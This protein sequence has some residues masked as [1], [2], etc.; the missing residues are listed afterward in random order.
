[1]SDSP[2]WMP[3]HVGDYLRDTGHLTV[4]EHGAYLLLIM[5]YWQDGSLPESDL[6][7][8]RYS[9]LNV[10]QWSE[11]RD[12]ILPMFEKGPRGRSAVDRLLKR[13]LL[14]SIPQAIRRFVM[15]RDG[16]RCRYCGSTAGPFELDHILPWS[17]G[18]K[19][20]ASNLTVACHDC[21]RAKGVLTEDEFLAATGGHP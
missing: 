6:L 10:E 9:H 3:L 8:R 18:C 11:S 4:V 16:G 17:R 2:P 1:M 20:E 19:H 15:Q 13:H 7:L 12:R 21:N 14:R 5:R